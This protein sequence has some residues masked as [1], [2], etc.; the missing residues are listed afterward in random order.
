[1]RPAASKLSRRRPHG[2]TTSTSRIISR[3][4]TVPTDFAV[5]FKEYVDLSDGS[6]VVPN[7]LVK[8]PENEAKHAAW[9]EIHK[10]AKKYRIQYL[11]RTLSQEDFEELEAMGFVWFRSEWIWE[12]QIVPGLVAYKENH[13]TLEVPR[14]FVVP[15]SEEWSKLS[16][17]FR[18]GSAVKDIR[19]NQY[20]VEDDPE[21]RQWL[22]DMGLVWDELERTWEVAKEAL[23]TYKQLHGDLEVPK[24]F[25]V[26]ESEKWREEMWGK[27]LGNTVSNIRTSGYFVRDSHERRQWLEEAGF[28]F[29]TANIGQ[30][31]NDEQW[32][33]K[34]LP[35]ITTYKQVH[36]DLQVPQDFVVPSSG[37]WEEGLWN[38][39]LGRAVDGIRSNS[40]FVRDRPDRQKQLDELGFVSDEFARQWE[41]VKETLA[42]HKRIYGDMTVKQSFVVPKGEEWPEEAWGMKLGLKVKDIRSSNHFVNGNPERR[43]WL[44]DEGFVWSLGAG[45]TE[46]AREAAVHFGRG[47][48][49]AVGATSPSSSTE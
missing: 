46:R 41:V 37:E 16:H 3:G 2:Y 31:A 32:E 35:A 26:P 10:P 1:M 14:S 24:S 30:A 39:Q 25:V 33:N 49:G 8:T 34:V 38:M 7:K 20:Q 42:M 15:A 47:R 22:E 44:E 19:S 28:R 11:N 13:G 4:L 45:T 21:R 9:S 40:Y 6:A 5:T 36:G 12:Q 17:G 18:L 27:K 43:Q 29:K 23:A 48:V